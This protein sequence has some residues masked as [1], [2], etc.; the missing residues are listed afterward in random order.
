MS[1]AN[2]FSYSP[3][4]GR[5]TRTNHSHAVG[6]RTACDTLTRRRGNEIM[7]GKLI[8]TLLGGCAIALLAFALVA[9]PA[10][11][12]DGNPADATG[13]CTEGW[14][15]DPNKNC[16]STQ[17]SRCGTEVCSDS[18]DCSGCSCQANDHA[19]PYCECLKTP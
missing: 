10:W 6:L 12:D 17:S 4:E 14:T 1:E 16:F 13:A 2:D 19:P 7:K 8:D 3:L 18:T 5:G 9:A 11:A 15:C